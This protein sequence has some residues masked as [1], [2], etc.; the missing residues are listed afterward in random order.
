[1]TLNVAGHPK[2]CFVDII[3]KECSAERCQL[4][5]VLYPYNIC[6]DQSLEPSKVIKTNT[7]GMA[8]EDILIEEKA[9]DIFSL[10]KRTLW[11]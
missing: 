3:K 4:F 7:E 8:E 9:S 5:D 11:P 1:M 6:K 10:E 2:R